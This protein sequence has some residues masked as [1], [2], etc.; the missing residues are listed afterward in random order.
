MIYQW[1]PLFNLEQGVP[2]HFFF[3]RSM[4][5]VDACG[6][7]LSSQKVLNVMHA[8]LEEVRELALTNWAEHEDVNT[9]Q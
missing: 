9:A 5:P 8:V 4:S 6:G 1:R 2:H 7:N 3:F